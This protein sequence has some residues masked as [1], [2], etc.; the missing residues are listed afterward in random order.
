M[1]G[2]FYADFHIH[3]CLSP[4]GEITM[5][6]GAVAERL[7]ELG[8]DWVAITD[9]N[10]AG[11]VRVFSEVLGK[12]GIVVIPGIE[13]HTLEDVHLLAFFKSVDIAEAYSDWL[14]N[15]I[16]NISVD[17]E[18]FGY[19]L[20]VNDKD[21][22]IAFEEKWLGQPA[23]LKL[24]EAIRS[25]IEFGGFYVY[26]HIE[27]KMGV[28]YQLGFIPM[29]E[30][31]NRIT[32]EISRKESLKT[33]QADK[34]LNLIHSSDAHALQHLKPVMKVKAEGR[35]FNEFIKCMSDRKRVKLL[36]E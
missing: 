34:R 16:P 27:R 7:Q 3:S 24:K 28:I 22:F 25:V 21:E 13:I 14:N 35:N 32:V 10:S 36:W 20:Y 2:E 30:E 8:I 6:P 9:H 11:N 19:Q 4:C 1:L 33:Y 31:N 26:S 17:P 29:L 5:T 15:L 23:N 12:Y 18:K